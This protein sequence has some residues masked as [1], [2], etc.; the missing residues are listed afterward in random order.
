MSVAITVL[1]DNRC[2]NK[3]CQEGWGFSALIE[4]QG[5]TLLFDTG[6]DYKAWASNLQ[7][8]GISYDKLTHLVFSHRHWDHCTGFREIV[9]H[10]PPHTSLCVP[11]GFLS[12]LRR[13]AAKHLEKQIIHTC[14]RIA[15]DIYSLVLRGGWFLY[16]QALV[17]KTSAGLGILTGC[18]HPGIVRIIKQ[19]KK[20]VGGEVAWVMGG[21]HQCFTPPSQTG[22]IVEEF[23][24]LGI[25][26][27]APCHCSG[28]HLIRQFE[29]TYGAHCYKV[30]A[31]TILHF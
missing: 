19:A 11:K 7:T 4:Y 3:A 20:Q 24:K 17:L 21:F 31:G 5:S 8:L 16:E 10:M 1:Y 9:R 27:V 30:G 26:K 13:S 6:G 2:G 12:F 14:A 28:E 22:K 25:K 15:P 23:Q 29:T 18:A